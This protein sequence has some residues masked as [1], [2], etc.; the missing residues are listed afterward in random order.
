MK[1]KK[2]A[3]VIKKTPLPQLD[4]I[5]SRT[6]IT[7]GLYYPVNDENKSLYRIPKY[8]FDI[9]KNQLEKEVLE[10][11]IKIVYKI[12]GELFGYL[13]VDN[14]NQITFIC[15]KVNE[16]YENNIIFIMNALIE[17][18]RFELNYNNYPLAIRCIVLPNSV[19]YD[20]E[21][22]ND[23]LNK[24]VKNRVDYTFYTNIDSSN[25]RFAILY[26]NKVIKNNDR[27]FISEYYEDFKTLKLNRV[28]DFRVYKN[29]IL[30]DWF[31]D[32]LIKVYKNIFNNLFKCS[33]FFEDKKP[34]DSETYSSNYI[35]NS[36]VG[37]NKLIFLFP[38][39][40]KIETIYK[41]I[42]E[43]FAEAIIE[44]NIDK[45]DFFNR[46]SF[47]INKDSK[48][49]MLDHKDIDNNCF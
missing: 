43:V 20:N 27:H 9:Y 14:L 13:H 10:N 19:F 45:I 44:N 23:L 11:E 22:S 39:C 31:I 3:K 41:I 26:N 37:L 29:N 7:C 33:S 24:Y 6:I 1:K 38:E 21:L 17:G 32:S 4:K 2:I 48:L 5:L 18:L 46:F 8:I 16:E 47:C 36:I 15:Y 28:L 42:R 30:E 34:D 35:T 25:Y 12:Q 49:N 40:V